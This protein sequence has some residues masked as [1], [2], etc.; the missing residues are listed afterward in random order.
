MTELPRRQRLQHHTPSWV[1]DGSLFFLTVCCAQRGTPQLANPPV[2]KVLADAV[3]HYLR[4]EK[5]WMTS[6]LVMPDHWHALAAFRDS[7]QMEKTIKDWKR[8]TAKQTGI[9]WQDGFFEH[10]LRSRQSA[11][12]KWHYIRLNPVRKGL[13]ATPDDWPYVWMPDRTAR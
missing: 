3:E 10:R 8:Y 9:A 2:F 4:S 13:V 5:W 7:A 12:E 1:D 11:E 6:F